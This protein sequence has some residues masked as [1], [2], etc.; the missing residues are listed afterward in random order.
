ME[1]FVADYKFYNGLTKETAMKLKVYDKALTELQSR[2]TPGFVRR[3]KSN[4]IKE[5]FNVPLVA[6]GT[7]YVSGYVENKTI[8]VLNPRITQYTTDTDDHV[9]FKMTTETLT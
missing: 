6:S 7:A 1:S 2:P 4:I 3:Y 8:L 5:I 9:L